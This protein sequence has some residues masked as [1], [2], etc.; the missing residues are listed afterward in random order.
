MELRCSLSS[1]RLSPRGDGVKE[2]SSAEQPRAAAD[3]A[4]SY[5]DKRPK[6]AGAG[7][8]SR[9]NDCGARGSSLSARPTFKFTGASLRLFVMDR[10]R[11]PFSTGDRCLPKRDAGRGVR[12]AGGAAGIRAVRGGVLIKCGYEVAQQRPDLPKPLHVTLT[13][14]LFF[15]TSAL[16]NLAVAFQSMDTWDSFLYKAHRMIGS[17]SVARFAG[18][19]CPVRRRHGVDRRL[20]RAPPR[21]ARG[22]LLLIDAWSGDVMQQHYF[23]VSVLSALLMHYYL[24]LR[25]D[26]VITRRERP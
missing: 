8:G 25:I 5:G 24:R 20:L 18:R 21:P 12:W 13:A 3:V 11:D 19:G 22:L 17:A 1:W 9:R 10:S 14:S 26:G 15:I 16:A 4:D 7:G 6:P 2:R 23:Y